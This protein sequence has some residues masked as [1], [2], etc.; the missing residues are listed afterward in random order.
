MTANNTSYPPVL[1][2]HLDTAET[3]REFFSVRWPEAQAVA[4]PERRCY[5]GFALRRGKLAE[6]VGVRVLL[7]AMQ[8][9]FKGHGVGRAKADVLQMPGMLL[10]DG[11][12]ILWEHRF[13]HAGDHPDLEEI[14]RYFAVAH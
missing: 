2:F 7:R 11:K 12:R 4:D 13:R 14:G 5:E 9:V 1:F 6:L 10:V 8:A 3:G